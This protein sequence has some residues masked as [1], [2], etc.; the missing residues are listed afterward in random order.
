MVSLRLKLAMGLCLALACDARR[1]PRAVVGVARRV[2]L[3]DLC[4]SGFVGCSHRPHDGTAHVFLAGNA[5]R[6]LLLCASRR[7][8]RRP[9][10]G[11]SLIHWTN[12]HRAYRDARLYLFIDGDWYGF[13][14][15]SMT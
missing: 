1:A 8:G 9:I 14:V 6:L 7:S 4:L 5:Y 11:R 13:T 2:M 10:R 12:L 3:L 15:A